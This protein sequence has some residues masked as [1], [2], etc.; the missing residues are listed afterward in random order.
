MQPPAPP[1][2]APDSPS[3]QAAAELAAPG[4]LHPR[5]IPVPWSFVDC[6]IVLMLWLAAMLV[7]GT[8]S[9]VVLLAVLSEATAKVLNLPITALMLIGLT[10]YYLRRRYPGV[11]PRLLGWRRPSWA[12]VGWGLGAGVL[13]L[14][15]IAFGIG[16]LLELLANALN[17]ELPEVQEGFREIASDRTAAPLLI[18][19]SVVIAPIAEEIFYRGMLFP[20]IHRRLG[21]WPAM[22]I[23]AT[24]FGLMHFETPLQEFLLVLLIII[25]L[26]MW[27]AWIYHR[28]GTLLVP[29]LAHATF[30]LVQV[31]ELIRQSSAT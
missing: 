15:V 19:G 7:V 6:L 9:F 20:A 18:L 28:R 13:A 21:L 5:D 12:D 26:G 25:P 27:L 8:L 3:S 4:E 1:E 22:G 23:S 2:P 24:L 31:S 29:I 30:N 17:G 10:T 14:G 11:A 16:T